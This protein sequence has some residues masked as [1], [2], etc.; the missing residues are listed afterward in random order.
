MMFRIRSGD[1][2]SA[3]RGEKVGREDAERALRQYIRRRKH[4]MSV[5]D[6]LQNFIL[7][8]LQRQLEGGAKG[9][10]NEVGRP[11][12]EH[13]SLT[14][15]AWYC[16]HM[17]ER[18]KGGLTDERYERI[19]AHLTEELIPLRVDGVPG[20]SGPNI[21]RMVRDFKRSGFQRTDASVRPAMASDIA[22]LNIIK[23]RL[24]CRCTLLLDNSPSNELAPKIVECWEKDQ[25]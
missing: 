12:D 7:D 24:F 15:W 10:H 17:D 13:E 8:G 23:A 16:F 20:L 3:L 11:K 22:E 6:D 14:M 2:Y 9:W 19:S 5:P 18:F 4:G 25:K 21:K 1:D